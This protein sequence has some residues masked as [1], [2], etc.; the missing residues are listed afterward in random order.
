MK[1]KHR[2]IEPFDVEITAMGKSGVGLGVAPDGAPIHVRWAPPGSTV[3]VM[4]QGKRKGVW[5]GRREAM[6][7]LP[8]EAAT[9]PCRVFGLCGGCGL[10]ELAHDA[11]TREKHKF[12]LAAIGAVDGVLV[13]PPRVG[14]LPY[15]YRNRVEFSFGV[16]RYLSEA[17]HQAG[18]PIAGQFLGFH[19]PE[20]FDRVVDV[21]YCWLAPEA[22]N[23]VLQTVRETVLVEG[24]PP[25]YDPKFHTGFWRH[26][27]VR[28]TTLGE[29]LV[30]IYTAPDPGDALP[31]I[32]RAA[33]A[34]QKLT[35]GGASVRGVAWFVNAG[36]ADV[37]RGELQQQWGEM[38]IHEHLGPVRYELSTQ[39]FFQTST[40]GAVALYDTIGEALGA[41][42][43]TLVDLYCGTGAI[44]LYVAKQFDAVVGVEEIPEAVADAKRNAE[45][46]GIL[47][48]TYRAAKVEAALDVLAQTQGR[49]A[50]VVDPPRVGLHPDAAKALAKA[51]AEVL[52]Y[53][54]CHPASLGRDRL[55]L[56]AGGWRMSELWTV[57]MF[58]QTGH[59][60][61]VARFVRDA[62]ATAE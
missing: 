31:W 16:R 53:V 25:P 55:L 35:V 50:L 9:P 49:R 36:V 1:K 52:V 24:S 14:S 29:L 18:H 8:A 7:S 59:V 48:A 2:F 38:L 39:S 58:P 43:G 61:A 60:E 46:N 23:A 40:R 41:A 57:D 21:D 45:R 47:N 15:G 54:A 11:Q 51:D 44:G 13:H 26:V 27:L 22:T 20:R 19:A 30:A 4:P 3:R 17:D 32:T 12:A 37:A 34:L 6:V 10:Q 28:E 42:G 56:E 33:E 62:S 5:S